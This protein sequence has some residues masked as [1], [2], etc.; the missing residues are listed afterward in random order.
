M[1]G[2]IFISIKSGDKRILLFVF[3]TG[4]LGFAIP[5]FVSVVEKLWFS[6][7]K[8]LG[9][10]LPNILLFLVYFLILLPVAIV[11]RNVSKRDE[12]FLLNS[13]G[14]LFEATDKSFSKSFFEKTW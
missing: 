3:L 8:I 5:A 10:I 14:S 6:L 9:L 7:S 2:L 12:L 13:K 4:I 1:L 11:Y